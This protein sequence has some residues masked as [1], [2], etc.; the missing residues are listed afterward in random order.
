MNYSELTYKI[1]FSHLRSVTISAAREVISRFGSIE[2]LFNADYH[3]LL[4]T[5]GSDKVIDRKK[6][7]EAMEKAVAEVQW[8][9]NNGVRALFFTDED[10]P[11]RLSECEDAPLLV[12]TLGDANLNAKHIISV[13]G[14]R[15]STAYGLSFVENF[16]SEISSSLSDV[17]IVSGLAYGVDVAAHRESL[18]FNVPTLGV[19]AHGLSTVYPASHRDIAAKMVKSGGGLLTEYPHSTPVAKGYFLA[20]NRIVAGIC[21]ALIV[22]ETAEKGGSLITA[23][24]ASAYGKPVF[25]LPGRTTDIYSAG[26]NRLIFNNSASLFTNTEDFI[27]AMM[28]ENRKVEGVQQNL[29]V[30]LPEQQ[31]AIYDYL[32]NEGEATINQMACELNIPVSQLMQTVGD[33]EFDELLM[34]MP[35]SKYRISKK[36]R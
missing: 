29:F 15:H 12:Y 32:V 1:A 14:T 22:V 20:R 5:L 24:L 35:G 10:Y 33:M 26:C 30:E 6:L 16:I 9:E 23:R 19:V 2:A 34:S 25:A 8:V 21:D 36:I 11:Q 28:W 27:S 7:D 18:K 13:V 3:L 17:L 4:S 31:K